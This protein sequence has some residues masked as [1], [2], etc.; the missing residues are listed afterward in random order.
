MGM[1]AYRKVVDHFG[2]G[3]LSR[4]GEISRA[5]LGKL[6]FENP[7]ERQVLNGLV[8]PAVRECFAAWIAERRR[9][10]ERAAGLIP[11]LYESGMDQ[12][13]WDAVLCVSSG[14]E[15]V[16][17]RLEQRGMNCEE[18]GLRMRA[19]M[20]LAEKE[21]RADHVVHNNGT[22][23]MLAAATRNTVNQVKAER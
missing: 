13:D 18:A 3:I 20:P 1:P 22:L 12:L 9:L 4:N 19:Q 8:H 17:Q 7:T 6:V 5:V 2:V 15:L 10:G 11:L 23:E 21:G 14:E 16:L